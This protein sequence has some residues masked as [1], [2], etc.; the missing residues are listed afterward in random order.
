[1]TPAASPAPRASEPVK[2]QSP[3]EQ[4]SYAFASVKDISRQTLD[5][6]IEL[7]KGYLT[8]T[9]SIIAAIT[10]ADPKSWADQ[11]ARPRESLA[12]RLSFEQNGVKLHELY[13]EQL[14]GET[15]AAAPAAG[16]VA[17]EAMDSAFGGFDRWRNDIRALGATRGVGWVVSSWDPSVE[18]LANVWVDLH[19]LSVPAGSRIVYVVDLWEHAFWNDFGSAG[20]AKYVDKVLENTDWSVVEERF[21]PVIT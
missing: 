19:H 6:H 11:V 16:S 21:G 8:Q 9:N 17:T 14:D 3:Y 20:R 1:M 18:Q 2:R 7:Y 15:R 10:S 13:F 5:A 12:R 4:Q